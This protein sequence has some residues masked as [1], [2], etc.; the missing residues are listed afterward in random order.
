M[1]E[2]PNKLTK[3]LLYKH[4]ILIKVYVFIKYEILF[5]I[6]GYISHIVTYRQDKDAI[7]Y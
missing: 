3:I 2:I 7:V 1:N 5:F 4:Y 6:H